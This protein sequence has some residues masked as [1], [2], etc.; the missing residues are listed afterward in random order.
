MKFSL[1]FNFDGLPELDTP[2]LLAQVE[3]QVI[4]ADRLGFDA[5]YLAEH[6]FTEYGRM[7]APLAFL[8]R[9]SALTS[10]VDLGT[11]V[12]EAPYYHPLRLAEE[13][14]LLDRISGG[15]LRLGVGSGAANKPL[16]FSRF[17]ITL[18]DKSPRTL[19]IT[20]IVRQ[21]LSANLVNFEGEYF[22]YQDVALALE[23]IRPVS[24]LLWIAA[25]S[26]SIVY[27]GRNSMPLMLPRPVP[28]SKN[29]DLVA[30]YRAALPVRTPGYVSALRFTFVGETKAE[31]LE[32]A[33]TTFQRYAKYDAGVDWDGQTSGSEYQGICDHLKFIAGTPDEVEA[34]IRLWA[35][36]LGFDEVMCQMY[37]AGTRCED[38]LRSMELFAR[39]VMPRFV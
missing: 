11:A 23:P 16:E 20:E 12:I 1:F 7:P 37:A 3:E 10:R 33:R 2:S 36:D 29:R 34:Q 8:A 27:A 5:I 17:G 22:S 24:E 21:A 18:E 4:A 32:I 35:A 31:A 14:A 15:R 13:A 26:K 38:A 28:E 39:E 25:S 6:H 9:L 19:E 30:G